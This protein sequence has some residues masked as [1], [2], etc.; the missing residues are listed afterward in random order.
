MLRKLACVCLVL[1]TVMPGRADAQ[2]WESWFSRLPFS[3]LDPTPFD[4]RTDPDIDM[5]ISHWENAVPRTAQGSL[6]VYDILTR[7]EGDPLHPT[8]KGAVLTYLVRVSYATLANGKSTTP[9]A[10]AGEQDIFYVTTGKGTLTAGGVAADLHAYVGILLPPGIEYTITNTGDETL[11]MYCIVESLPKGFTPNT[12]MVVRDE[13]TIPLLSVPGHWAH[14]PKT[15]FW[16]ETDNTAVLIGM[17]PVWIDPMTMSQPHS[18]QPGV[19]EVWLSIE[20]GCDILLGK[21]IR[22]FPPGSAMRI[23]ANGNTPHSSINAG[24]EPIKL[25]WMM[26]IPAFQK[27]SPLNVD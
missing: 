4:P 17:N 20:E 2:G 8:R 11:A 1:T 23:P 22:R 24:D 14:V 10:L 7:N 12:T 26:R 13:D 6:V 5:Y 9:H 18:H 21:Q 16:Q 25:L 19:E 3:H 15:L 27:M